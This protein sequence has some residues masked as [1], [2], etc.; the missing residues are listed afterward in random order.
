MLLNHH[1]LMIC[2]A[3]SDPGTLVDYYRADYEP[4]HFQF[5]NTLPNNDA[6]HFYFLFMRE[7]QI[8]DRTFDVRSQF[9]S[10]SFD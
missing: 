4:I 2:D 10:K 8:I 5:G 6:Y 3:H 1:E 9:S 7:Y